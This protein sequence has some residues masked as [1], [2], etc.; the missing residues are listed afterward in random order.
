MINIL[1]KDCIEFLKG[2]EEKFDV[3]LTSPPYNNSRTNHT[4]Y[5]MRTANCRYAEY[6]DNKT[7][8]E[9][10]AW[11]VQLFNLLDKVL[12]KNGTI[13]YNISYGNENPTVM[14]EA[15]FGIVNQTPFMIAENIVWK[16]S[17]AFPNNVSHNKLTRITEPVFVFCRKDEYNSYFMNKK[18]KSV[19][20]TGQKFYENVFNYI[21]AP[22][23]DGSNELNNAT[24]STGLCEK[25]LTLYCPKKRSCVRPIYGYWNDSCCLSETWNVL[26]RNGDI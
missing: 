15:L 16:K 3:V 11:T 6:D 19:S 23:N 2:T 22:N 8:E 17:S 14:W 12:V 1:N 25:L 26:H 7:N 24:Y 5:S 10:V 21:E 18:V 9:Y 4:E 20:K 13:L